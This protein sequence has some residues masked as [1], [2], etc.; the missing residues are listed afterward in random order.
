[1]RV[2]YV[3]FFRGSL[4]THVG[5]YKAW[6]DAVS[7]S[8]NINMTTFMTTRSYKAQE[9]LVEKYAS[10]GVSIFHANSF[11]LKMY[12][13]AYFL[14]LAL[15]YDGVIVHVRKQNTSTLNVIKKITKGKL[16][17]IVDMEGDIESELRYL[18]RPE[19]N[20]YKGFYNK[21]IKNLRAVAKKI[22]NIISK[23]DAVIVPTEKMKKVYL[24]RYAGIHGKKIYAL[25]TSFSG[26][27]FYYDGALRANTRKKL[28]FEGKTVVVFCGALHYSWQNIKRSI[29]VFNK[30]D[31]HGTYKN[32]HFYILTRPQDYPIAKSFMA[33]LN[34]DSSR[35]T[36]DNVPHEDVNAILNASDIG[37]LLRENVLLNKVVSTGKLGE[38]LAAGLPVITTKHIGFYSSYLENKDFSYLFDDIYSDDELDRLVKKND[39]LLPEAERFD[40][41]KWAI[42][43]LSVE[44]Q[45]ITYLNILKNVEQGSH[46][47]TNT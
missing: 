40:V 19:K 1:M 20:L 15:K 22:G 33:H 38:Y 28:G 43:E 36:L 29:E 42:S 24:S 18:E 4:K 16:R 9:K 14:F 26:S 30:L 44:A 31:Q 25:P 37:I 8:I 39:L 13:P 3:Y 45:R 12:I 23:A 17:Y 2:K 7:D 27:K 35:Y 6:V 46:G 11:I 10:Q 21:E 47:F 32:L 41:S 5:L 34:V